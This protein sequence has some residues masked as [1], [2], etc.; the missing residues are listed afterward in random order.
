MTDLQGLTNRKFQ[1]GKTAKKKEEALSIQNAYLQSLQ[2]GEVQEDPSIVEP[3]GPS[4]MEEHLAKR[5]RKEEAEPKGVR[6]PFDREK[7]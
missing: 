1:T 4:L 3:S 7:V 6:R 2:E 5:A